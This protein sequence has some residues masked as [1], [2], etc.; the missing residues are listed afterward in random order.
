MAQPLT[1]VPP[2]II[3]D[4]K[5]PSITVSTQFQ[6][7]RHIYNKSPSEMYRNSILTLLAGASSLT[8]A[9]DP[10]HAILRAR[11][12]QDSTPTST[13]LSIPPTRTADSCRS[14]IRDMAESAPSPPPDLLSYEISKQAESFRTMTGPPTSRITNLAGASSLCSSLYAEDGTGTTA[15]TYPPTTVIA[16]EDYDNYR[17]SALSWYSSLRPAVSE[18]V[19]TCSQRYPQEVGGVWLPFTGNEE[20]CVSA[21]R[22]FLRLTATEIVTQTRTV[23][24]ETEALTTESSTTETGAPAEETETEAPAETSVSTAGAARETGFVVAVVAAAAGV[25]GVMGAM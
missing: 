5:L 24:T 1:Q 6:T 12:L 11:Q 21:Y 4:N 10:M 14:S 25:A 17:S 16:S 7:N 8:A 9:M 19:K 15:F 23:S 18:L 13:F 3:K 22:L 20:E 2:I